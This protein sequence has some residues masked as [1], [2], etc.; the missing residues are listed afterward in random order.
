MRFFNS[1]CR[2]FKEELKVFR[3]S[4]KDI[5]HCHKF[6]TR[7]LQR[8]SPASVLNL[9]NQTAACYWDY[10]QNT[11]VVLSRNSNFHQYLHHN[12]FCN[13]TSKG[14]NCLTHKPGVHL[15]Q[16]QHR[17]VNFSAKGIV[18]ASPSK[19]Q[20]Y[21]RLL[22][23]DRPI[24]TYLLFWPC[25]WSIGL[26]AQSGCL[27][28]LY[29]LTLF[30]IG[31]FVMR[32]AGCIINDLWDKDIDKMVE[33]TK[34]RPLASGELTPLQALVF[35]GGN[36]SIALTI[37]LQLNWF[38]VYLGAASMLLVVAYPLAKRYTYWPQF[39]LGKISLFIFIHFY[40]LYSHE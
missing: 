27:P 32:G 31:S 12:N 34:T 3:R 24:G 18:D 36:L 17:Y 29:M 2:L 22:R 8:L 13:L 6:C 1:Q 4:T 28:D 33:R 39:V 11:P 15:N 5:L 38:S 20:P 9:N 37:L 10:K 40:V 21:L 23:V 16:V 14:F 25:T 26:A 7:H 35:L 30:G 19:I